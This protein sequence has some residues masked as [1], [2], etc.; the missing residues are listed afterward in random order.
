MSLLTLLGLIFGSVIVFVA[1]CAW[2]FSHY[3]DQDHEQ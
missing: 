1:F 2:W 3:M